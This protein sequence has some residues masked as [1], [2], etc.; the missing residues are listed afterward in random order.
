MAAP[1]REVSA[2]DSQLHPAE[3]VLF[4]PENPWQSLLNIFDA[5]VPGPLC[6]RPTWHN[7]RPKTPSC[8][9]SAKYGWSRWPRWMPGEWRPILVL[10]V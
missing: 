6:L 2:P 9:S 3:G 8:T 1:R 7:E 10:G 5:S 4:N